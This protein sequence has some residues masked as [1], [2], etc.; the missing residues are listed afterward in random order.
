MW[1]DLWEYILASPHPW[2]MA[3]AVPLLML[4]IRDIR[5]WLFQLLLYSLDRLSLRSLPMTRDDLDNDR[6]VTTVLDRLRFAMS[7]DRARVWAFVNGGSFTPGNPDWAAK[8]VYEVCDD[9][10]QGYILECQRIPVQALYEVIAPLFSYQVAGV[11]R[12]SCNICC[13]KSVCSEAAKRNIDIQAW[14]TDVCNMSQ[15]TA[16][17]MLMRQ[18]VKQM[19][20][21]PM[22]NGP[23]IIGFISVDYVNDR[24]DMNLPCKPLLDCALRITYQLKRSSYFGR[25]WYTRLL[26]WLAKD[27]DKEN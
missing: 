10:I 19:L 21:V 13:N 16:K 9:G 17:A 23:R 18:G 20:T 7:A 3:V 2:F 8:T 12:L 15:S 5:R 6:N 27:A 22:L 11:A 26:H 1:E 24:R 4:F 25:H 14:A